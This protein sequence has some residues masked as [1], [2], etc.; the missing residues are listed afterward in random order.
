M[1][2]ALHG[3]MHAMG[4]ITVYFVRAVSKL[5]SLQV[6]EIDYIGQ[7]YKTFYGRKLRLFHNKL[8]SLSARSNVFG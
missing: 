2:I 7:C 3:S 6:Y 8:A 1:M 5:S 4:D